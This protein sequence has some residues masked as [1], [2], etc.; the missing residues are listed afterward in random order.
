MCQ[1][2]IW[3]TLYYHR[4]FAIKTWWLERKDHTFG[5]NVFNNLT[6]VGHY[7]QLVWAAT[8][9]V[10]CGMNSCTMQQNGR[11]IP[12]FTYICNYCPM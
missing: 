7:T 12:Y 4:L 8:H 5:D 10:G 11:S 3:S 2:E 6:L 9:K 1:C